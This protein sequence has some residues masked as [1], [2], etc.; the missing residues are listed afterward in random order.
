[1]TVSTYNVSASELERL[2]CEASY[3]DKDADGDTAAE[4]AE[5]VSLAASIRRAKARAE[6]ERRREAARARRA[7][8]F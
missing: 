8:F 5:Q 7:R 1:M 3:Y 6:E 2:V 4:Y